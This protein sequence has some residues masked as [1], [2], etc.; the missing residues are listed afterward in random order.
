MTT[1]TSLGGGRYTLV[2]HI[3]TGG[4][5]QVW[6]ATDSVL[7]RDVAVKI[8]KTEYA[9]DPTF[10]ARLQAEARNTAALVHPGI[11]QVFDFGDVP[12]SG[13]EPATAFLVMELVRG[14]P[15][16]AILDSH[17]PLPP[18][19]A[20]EVVAQA[21]AAID[22]AHR[23]GIV[24]RDVKPANLL[25][26]PEGE[27]K[28]TDFGI[29]RAADALPLT[30]TGQVIGTPQYLSPE[31]AQGRPATPA[32]D[33]YSLG[34]VLYECLTGSRPFDADGGVAVA[35]QH[36][37]EPPPPLPDTVPAGLA[38]VCMRALS[39]DP[40][41]RMRS[42]GELADYL[43]DP[44]YAPTGLTAGA[45]GTAATA[46]T[47]A[48]GPALGDTRVGDTPVGGTAVGDPGG[49]GTAMMTGRGAHASTPAPRRRPRWLVPVLLAVAVLALAAVAAFALGGDEQSP[50]GDAAQPSAGAG[51]T[52]GAGDARQRPTQSA[53]GTV[54]VD[55]DDYLDRP[56]PEARAEL[57]DMGLEVQRADKV[58]DG[59]APGTVASVRPNGQVS[60]GTTVTL[61][62]WQ[63]PAPEDSQDSGDTGGDDSGG[64]QQTDDN[65]SGKS[66][67]SGKSDT[68]GKSKGNGS[69]G[70][71]D[72]GS[73]LPLLD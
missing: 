53:P 28:V 16:S 18:D 20:A 40:E 49:G 27:V 19:R 3:A 47:A 56:Y 21:A 34:V 26:T 55:P 39:K 17:G 59:G 54:R 73:G 9:H 29:A 31:Q 6:Q 30:Q 58:G 65:G 35:M 7:G 42:A 60:K 4:M 24:H 67:D 51:T 72:D 15:L 11:A 33:V 1:A 69:S 37:N 68:R 70:D 8:L 5:G 2:E 12:A 41:E 61:E 44:D 13:S 50:A 43:R 48:A 14:R 46:A 64:E 62:V 66:K 25:A 63:A 22:V 23:Q 10:R 38:A 71:G 57:Q 32:S 52:P 45:A 36:L